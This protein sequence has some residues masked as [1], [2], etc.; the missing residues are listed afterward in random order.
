MSDYSF[1]K[2]GLGNAS[3]TSL[4]EIDMENIEILLSLFI[5]NA[6][7]NASKYVTHCNR[8]GVTKED[9]KYGLRYEV[10]EFLKRSNL[11]DDIKKATQEYNQY[12]DELN[13]SDYEENE[14]ELNTM[15]IPDNEINPFERINSDL[16]C[17]QNKIFIETYHNHNDNWDKWFPIT[18]LDKILKNAIDKI[19]I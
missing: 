3:Q 19:D 12:L 7:T 11:M 13:D 15:I 5:S 9:I 10:F 2:S 16:I 8:N 14:D 4:S 17:E 1:M 18:P 6:I